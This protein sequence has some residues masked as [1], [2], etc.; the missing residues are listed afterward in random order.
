MTNLDLQQYFAEQCSVSG[1]VIKLGSA[2]LSREDY[3]QVKKLLE[4]RGGK[5]KGGKMSGFVFDSDAGAI[6]DSICSGDLEN[7]KNVYQ[8]FPTPDEIADRM[9]EK[10]DVQL[11]EDMNV[12][13]PSAGRGAL[14]NAFH[15]EFPDVVVEAWE[16]N[17]DCYYALEQ[18]ENVRL[19]K[20][21]FMELPDDEEM[22]DYIIA[23]P[24]FAKNAD[25]KHF[26]RMF[27]LL[28][29]GGRLCCILSSHALEASGREE[30]EFKKWLY[31]LNPE[32]EALPAGTFKAAGTDVRT[33]MVTV[34][35]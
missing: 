25:I 29:K 5:W 35:K 28:K 9:V 24:P 10:L 1:N 13:E 26:K 30:T 32:V 6:Y 27:N 20:Y 15:R 11:K 12:L 2:Q 34:Q 19:V 17:P 23:N 18:L 31:S 21:D 4:S 22:Y 16:I 8:F 3:L 33:F 14:I 7:K